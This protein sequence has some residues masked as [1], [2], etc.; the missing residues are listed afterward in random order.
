MQFSEERNISIIQELDT[1]YLLYNQ[2][3]TFKEVEVNFTN[4]AYEIINY[5]AAHYFYE[6]SNSPKWLLASQALSMTYKEISTWYMDKIVF[7]TYIY[8]QFST[9]FGSQDIFF[10]SIGQY[11]GKLT[12]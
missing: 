5:P 1:G 12:P 4:E 10:S 2:T 8:D 9:Y 6:V 7:K 3:Q 11:L